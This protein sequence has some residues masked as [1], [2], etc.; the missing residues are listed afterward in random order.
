MIERYYGRSDRVP[1]GARQ[2][3]AKQLEVPA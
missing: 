3:A 1:A 2:A